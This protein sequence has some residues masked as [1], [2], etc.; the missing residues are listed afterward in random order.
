MDFAKKNKAKFYNKF[1]LLEVLTGFFVEF[2]NFWNLKILM[3]L[4]Y[5][6]YLLS[7]L[8]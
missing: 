8:F 4:K 3:S 5:R 6:N 1:L 2:L 7:Y